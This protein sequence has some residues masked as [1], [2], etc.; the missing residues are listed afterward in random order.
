MNV[1]YLIVAMPMH[2]VPTLWAHILASVK[3]AMPVTGKLVRAKAVYQLEWKVEQS[4]MS[5][6]LPLLNGTPNGTQVNKE[7]VDGWLFQL[8]SR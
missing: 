6:S 8:V 1:R 4:L 5:A 2:T 3:Q 7:G